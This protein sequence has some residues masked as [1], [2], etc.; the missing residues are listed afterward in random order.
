[1]PPLKNP[2]HESYV[3]LISTGV[4][5]Y[6]A[7]RINGIK[8]GRT[9]ILKPQLRA[10]LSEII[11][12]RDSKIDSD[13]RKALSATGISKGYV[14]EALKEIVEKSMG[15]MMT[16]KGLRWDAPVAVRALELIGREVGMFETKVNVDFTAKITKMTDD[17]LRKF[18]E[19]ESRELGIGARDIT[20]PK[21]IGPDRGQ[22]D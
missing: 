3:Q 12:E 2:Q 11:I 7:G 13:N 9:A 17:E 14:L 16:T 15:R 22:A 8:N 18:I 4:D 6:E 20:P 5:P 21:S 10:R 19:R 1:M